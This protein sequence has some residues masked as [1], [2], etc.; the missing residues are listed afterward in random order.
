VR[1]KLKKRGNGVV[2]DI[3]W[4]LFGGMHREIES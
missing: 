2:V 3:L 1:Y 4:S